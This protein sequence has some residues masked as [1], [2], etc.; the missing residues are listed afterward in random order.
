MVQST[1]SLSGHAFHPICQV[2]N[3]EVQILYHTTQWINFH[4]RISTLT[5]AQSLCLVSMKAGTGVEKQN[6]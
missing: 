1:R 4:L 2:S 5:L 3:V 6:L